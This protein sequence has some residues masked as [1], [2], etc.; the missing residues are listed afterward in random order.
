MW[1]SFCKLVSLALLLTEKAAV[2][3]EEEVQKADVSSTGQSVIDKDALGPMMLEVSR[4]P[5]LCSDVELKYHTLNTL[6]SP[7]QSPS[8]DDHK[9][10]LSFNWL[11]YM[12]QNTTHKG[13]N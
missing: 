4:G 12:M 13:Y 10:Y 5:F 7:S 2:A 11:W 3:N 6:K 8:T 1:F 9:I